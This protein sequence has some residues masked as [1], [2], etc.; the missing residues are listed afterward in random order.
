MVKLLICFTSSTI[1]NINFKKIIL[2]VICYSTIISILFLSVF[3]NKI[4]LLR[5]SFYIALACGFFYLFSTKKN[6]KLFL[7][8]LKS[9]YI[10]LLSFIFTFSLYE[11]ISIKNIYV[12]IQSRYGFFILL[13]LSLL[14]F[15]GCEILSTKFITIEKL[16]Y[17]LSSINILV[18]LSMFVLLISKNYSLFYILNFSRH[19]YLVSAMFLGSTLLEF[20]FSIFAIAAISK[21]YDVS[22]YKH[23]NQILK[24]QYDLQVNSFN[25]LEAH[26]ADIRRI[27]HDIHNHKTILYNLIQEKNYDTALNYLEKYGSSF[28]NVKYELLTNNKILNALFLSKKGICLNNHINVNFDISLP[29]TINISDFDLC[30]LVGNLFDNAIEACKKM[31]SSNNKYITIKSKIINNN[32][33]FELK[34][35]FNG[36]INTDKNKFLTLKKDTLNHGLGISNVKSTTNKY[37]GIC[38]FSIENNEFSA[39]VRIPIN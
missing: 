1:L 17:I 25:Q 36:I 39:F 14:L 38:D 26:Q 10:F 18:P 7:L 4:D 16:D 37:A 33:V 2:L 5:F 21:S 8:I 30:I 9:Y 29:E 3:S 22:L 28:N 23:K 20:Y 15:A 19:S 32:F 24:M 34:N 27:S 35:S 13:I 11:I 12:L 31:D 6:F